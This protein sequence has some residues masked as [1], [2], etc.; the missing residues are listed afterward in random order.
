MM[1]KVRDMIHG[2][3][4]FLCLVWAIGCGGGSGGGSGGSA[5]SGSNNNSSVSSQGHPIDHQ[6]AFLSNPDLCRGC[7]GADLLGGEAG[8][9]CFSSSFAGTSCHASGPNSHPAGWAYPDQHGAVAKAAP[10]VRN[11]F[12]YCQKCHGLDF[13]GGFVNVSC[14]NCHIESVESGHP[15]S[16]IGAAIYRQHGSYVIASG[17]AQCSNQYCHGTLLTGVTG[18]G[19]SC[20]TCHPWDSGL[21]PGYSYST[22]TLH[23]TACH[24]YPPSG[25]QYPDTAG[26]HAK[27]TVLA[28]IDCSTCHTGAGDGTTNH[29]NGGVEVSFSPEF[30]SPS[31]TATFDA[32]AKKCSNVS[33][34]GGP[35]MQTS[36][37]ANM[38]PPESTVT[39]TLDW[40]NGTITV[41]TDCKVCH[42]YGRNASWKEDNSYYSGQHRK[43]VYG[44]GKTCTACHDTNKLSADHFTDLDTPELSDPAATIADAVHY[45]FGSCANACHGSKDW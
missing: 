13:K 3:L 5:V 7:H 30:D 20:D 36:P 14:F 40:I 18:S 28:N 1:R 45:S 21:I 27:H 41:D 35:R 8:V 22:G 15:V 4:I 44:E 33:C 17:S 12:S 32:T 24:D 26:K 39:Q 6:T 10:G 9:S 19:P 42:V 43:H 23:C 34:H 25:T 16:W 29:Y 37:Q 2:V 11:G 38:S 31:G